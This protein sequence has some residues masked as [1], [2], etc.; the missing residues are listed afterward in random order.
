MAIRLTMS[1]HNLKTNQSNKVSRR[2]NL[3]IN[4]LEINV[5]FKNKSQRGL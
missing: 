3:V 1:F 4:L 5:N 2:D